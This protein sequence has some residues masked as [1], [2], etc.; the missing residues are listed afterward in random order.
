MF[1]VSAPQ[2]GPPDYLY[3]PAVRSLREY[4]GNESVWRVIAGAVP[5]VAAPVV[6]LAGAF[7]SIYVGADLKTFHVA[8]G[9]VLAT[10][11]SSAGEILRRRRDWWRLVAD[12]LWSFERPNP[13]TSVSVQIREADRP[14]AQV[15]LRGAH[16]HPA[17]TLRTGATPLDAPDLTS[18]VRVEEPE[19]WDTSSDD[20][21]RIDRIYAVLT[22]AGVRARVGGRDVFPAQTPD[23]SGSRPEHT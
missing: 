8:L 20:A 23:A 2:L 14:L 3:W 17:A 16:F 6:P 9:V 7:A 1:E 22:A 21:N 10:A 18:Q 12:R 15:A 5:F 19:A 4:E 13:A 11:S